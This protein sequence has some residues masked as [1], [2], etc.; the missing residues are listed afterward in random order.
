MEVANIEMLLKA[1]GDL[2]AKKAVDAARQ[3]C[4][5]SS[6]VHSALRANPWIGIGAVVVVFRRQAFYKHRPRRGYGPG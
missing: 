4:D 1:K 5:A 2:A 3:R 6:L